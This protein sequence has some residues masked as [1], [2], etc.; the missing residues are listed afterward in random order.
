MYSVHE[1][2]AEETPGLALILNGDEH[3][4]RE[5]FAN[6][7]LPIVQSY[8]LKAK[9]LEVCTEGLSAQDHA[10]M[11]LEKIVVKSPDF[12]RDRDLNSDRKM[13][14]Y[15]FRSAKNYK[16]DLVRKQVGK[17]HQVDVENDDGEQSHHEDQE[18]DE[19]RNRRF[20][21]P[22]RYV[23]LKQMLGFAKEAM[24]KLPRKT[25]HMLRMAA[26]GASHREIAEEF[27][28][29]VSSV[30]SRLKQAQRKLL[31]KIYEQ[32]PQVRGQLL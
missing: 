15:L 21:Q 30:G 23:I 1:V 25:A 16:I 28:V 20:L 10:C 26:E 14:D 6:H 13:Q 5:T 9:V 24:P 22:D 27:G 32:N 8:V 31:S 4:G 7:Y 12:F 17:P 11:I 18:K 19:L 3:K 29:G 2:V